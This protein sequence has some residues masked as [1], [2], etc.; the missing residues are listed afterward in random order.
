MIYAILAPNPWYFVL[1]QQQMADLFD[2]KRQTITK[3]L[4]NIFNLKELTENSV[5]SILDIPAQDGKE[6]QNK[7]LSSGCDYIGWLSC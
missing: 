4:K 1:S 2:T 3:H 5:C 7:I 6:I